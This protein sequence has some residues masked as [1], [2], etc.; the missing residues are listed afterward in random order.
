[1]NVFN[2]RFLRV[3][4]V[5]GAVLQ[6]VFVAG[7]YGTGREIVE[8]FSQYGFE[9]G[10]FGIGV[11]TLCWT[12]VMGVTFEFARCFRAYDYRSFFKALLGRGWFLFEVLYVLMLLLVLAVVASAAGEILQNSF[13]L[14]YSVGLILM[15]GV[16]GLLTF[17]GREAVTKALAAWSFFLYAVFAV[18]FIVCLM[19]FPDTIG[20]A[21]AAGEVGSGWLVSGFTYAMYNLSIVPAVLFAARDIETRQEAL[22]S[23]CAA[24]LI[25]IIPAVLFHISFAAGYPDV[26]DQEIPAYWMIERLELPFLLALYAV[27]IFGT[28]VETGAGYVQGINERIDAYLKEQEATTM[29]S[30]TRAAVAVGGILVS[31]GLATLGIIEL[32][33][34]GY[35]TIAWGF[36]AVYVIP[37]LT[38]GI[39]KIATHLPKHVPAAKAHGTSPPDPPGPEAH[40]A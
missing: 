32:I 3:Y 27:A 30:L 24:A 10:L 34:S 39:Y 35:G 37:V 15:L 18:Y 6:S 29:S 13:G 12:L 20:A 40:E 9:G 21:F 14:P 31:A 28:F 19:A 2:A 38:Y 8:Y 16:V 26:L 17:F 33:A 7:G 23:G 25:C 22:T 1:M 4:I 5:P 11:T 36:F